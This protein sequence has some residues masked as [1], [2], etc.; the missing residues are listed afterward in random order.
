MLECIAPHV[1]DDNYSDH[2]INVARSQPILFVTASPPGPPRN[3]YVVSATEESIKMAWENPTVNAAS[4][5]AT[6]VKVGKRDQGIFYEN[7]T[8]QLSP[9]TRAY[10]FE[11]LTPKTEYTFIFEAVTEEDLFDMHEASAGSVAVS[12]AFTNGV[13][14]P[15]N[16]KIC[17]RAPTSIAVTWEHAVVYGMSIIQH[18]R[19]HYVPNRQLRKKSRGR[20]LLTKDTGKVLVVESESSTAEL[21]GLDPGT[22]YR[23]VVEAVARIKDYSYDEDFESD[24]SGT[25]SLVSSNLSENL[26]EMQQLYLSGPLLACTSAPPEPPVLLV[27]GFTATQVKLSWRKPLV[28][29]P[30][31]KKFILGIRFCSPNI[32]FYWLIIFMQKLLIGWEHV[33]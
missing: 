26:P 19:V 12:S 6:R 17:S 18:Y 9:E 15:G 4:L 13:D 20:F 8:I 11:S 16:L 25:N 22:V 27:S 32:L 28:L 14:S 2:P 1:N 10:I 23:I 29:G 3:I 24:E 30:G 21:C 33:I 5:A 7:L 31:K